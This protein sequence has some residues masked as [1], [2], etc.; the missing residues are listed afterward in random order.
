MPFKAVAFDL[1][2][3]L[4]KEKSSWYKIHE[5]YGTLDRSKAHMYEYEQGKITYE[6]FMKLDIGLWK[7]IPYRKDIENILL[8]YNLCE[9]VRNVISTLSS[10]GYETCIVTTAPNILANAVSEELGIRKVASNGFN[11]DSNNLLTQNVNFNVDL[12]KKEVAFRRIA[13]EM[14][15]SCTDFIA[16][17]DSKYDSTFLKTAGLGI[18]YNSDEKLREVIKEN[19][20][21]MKKILDFI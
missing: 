8:T 3:T 10:K 17:G 1:D 16:I 11:F 4:V 6:Q 7:P 19:I 14:G 15:L 9:N 12:L 2:G 13:N 5:H 18:G 21:D 20:T